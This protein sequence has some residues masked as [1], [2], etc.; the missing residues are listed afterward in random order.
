M[1]RFEETYWRLIPTLSWVYLRDEELVRGMS[2]NIEDI[3]ESS[4]KELMFE[5]LT[6]ASK[7]LVNSLA[8][9]KVTALG[10]RNGKGDLEAIPS[11]A[12]VDLKFYFKPDIAAPEK[13]SRTSATEWHELQFLKNEV[14]SVWPEKRRGNVGNKL[15]RGA[16]KK[17]YDG[18]IVSLNNV[19]SRMG[20]EKW[21]ARQTS[22][23]LA[24]VAVNR[25]TEDELPGIMAK[26]TARKHLDKLRKQSDGIAPYKP[27]K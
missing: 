8:A 3:L 4:S 14:V 23:K 17:N 7:A 12:W 20:G 18:L 15:K 16:P 24:E 6:K 13:F 5:G 1:D 2:D 9:G 10:L 27:D 21:V 26:G 19:A 22:E 25:M 11:I